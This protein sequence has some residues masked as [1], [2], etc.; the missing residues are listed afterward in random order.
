MDPTRSSSH[1]AGPS[2]QSP[3]PTR[4]LPSPLN[5]SGGSGPG[6]ASFPPPS[7]YDDSSNGVRRVSGPADASRGSY[8]T[9]QSSS[10][11]SVRLVPLRWMHT[12]SCHDCSNSSHRQVPLPLAHTR[13]W[14]LPRDLSP[15]R[16]TTRIPPHPSLPRPPTRSP[17]AQQA[18]PYHQARFVPPHPTTNPS[19]SSTSQASPRPLRSR[20]ASSQSCTLATT[21]SS[22]AP[23]S[24]PVL[25]EARGGT[26]TMRS[27]GTSV[28]RRRTARL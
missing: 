3:F 8:R 9:S 26:S 5:T 12:S 28:R 13:P 24:S 15:R 19:P 22:R 23:F 10:G 20:S 6:R 27:C 14:Y 21:S 1:G 2:R 18:S 17:A 4:P 7:Y 11:S 25:E 16:P